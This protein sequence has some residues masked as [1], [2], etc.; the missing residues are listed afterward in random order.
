[1]KPTTLAVAVM[2]SLSAAPSL[3]LAQS[4]VAFNTAV[5]SDYR[6][7]GISQSRF[8]PALS[9]GV[10]VTLP[11]GFYVGAWAS[12]IKWI[13]DWRG[14]A[15]AEIDL[16]AGYKGALTGSGLGFDIGVLQYIYPSAKT[17]TWDTVYKDPNTTEIYGALTA[18]IVT[19]K[20]SYAVTNLFGNYNFTDNKKSDGSYYFD[21]SAP[22][23]LGS[24]YTLTPHVGYQK[25]ENI[26][27]AS[28][29]DY[30]LTISKEIN[31]FTLSAAVIG[32]DADKTFYKV[33]LDNNNK[34]L[35]RSSLVVTAKYSF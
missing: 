8:K 25:V 34:S 5:T 7:R 22:F 18:G 10:D 1:M 27:N 14:D 29:T 16:Y 21:L 13:K 31:A 26:A 12:S 23:A 33:P 19:A 35:G 28:Y 17:A 4:S 20:L 9:A 11:E 30:A 6:Y 24:G 3:T 15:N 2:L 32:T